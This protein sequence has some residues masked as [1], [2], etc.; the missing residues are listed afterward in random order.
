MNQENHWRTEIPPEEFQTDIYKDIHIS[1]LV[2]APDLGR[3]TMGKYNKVLKEFQIDGSPSRWNV[4]HWMSVPKI[5]N[6]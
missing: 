3:V 1:L 4:T 2:Y 6:A 5:P